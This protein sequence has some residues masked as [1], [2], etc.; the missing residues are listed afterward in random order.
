M[1]GLESAQG[2]SADCTTGAG[3][4]PFQTLESLTSA[5]IERIIDSGDDLP[6]MRFPLSEA[7]FT[8]P[9]ITSG[10]QGPNEDVRKRDEGQR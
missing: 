1:Q 5:D 7:S 3:D 10:R 6:T 2:A 8:S 9:S 4:A